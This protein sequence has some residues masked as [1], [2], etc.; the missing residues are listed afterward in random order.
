MID[1][2]TYTDSTNLITVAELLKMQEVTA[3]FSWITIKSIVIYYEPYCEAQIRRCSTNFVCGDAR[4][5]MKR[6]KPGNTVVISIDEA[7]N[8]QGI[9]VY[10]N[11]L[12]FRIK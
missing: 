6:L 11:P 8:R 4:E 7:V 2:K 3:N 10:I 1:G 9:K 12:L 5:F